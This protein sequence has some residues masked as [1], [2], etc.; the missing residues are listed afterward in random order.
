[1]HDRNG[2]SRLP[3]L[4]RPY[5]SRPYLSRPYLLIAAALTVILISLVAAGSASA[6][7][8]RLQLDRV[9]LDLPGPPSR[10][11]SVDLD[12]DGLRD[13][14]VLVAFTEWDQLSIEESTEMDGIEGLVEVLTIVPALADRREL[15]VFL[16]RPGGGF[17]AVDHVLPVGREI[18]ALE[19][20]TDAVPVVTLT[21]DGLSALRL[22]GAERLSFEPLVEET[23]V[24]AGVGTFLPRLPM[25]HD[26]DGDGNR[27]VF[28]PA[29]DGGAVYLSSAETIVA[30]AAS[31]LRL[32]TDRRRAGGRT[33]RFFPMPR[34]EDVDGDGLP[35][36][37]F[38][39][40][41]AEDGLT[42]QVLGN[43]GQGRFVAEPVEV[44]L[45]EP[46]P[47][48]DSETEATAEGTAERA[49]ARSSDG[50][51]C[52]E[53]PGDFGYFGDLDGDGR[54]EFVRQQGLENDDAGF[55]ESLDQAK[56]PPFRYY[57]YRSLPNLRAEAEPYAV[58]DALGYT[59]ESTSDDG[60]SLFV[61]GGFQDL[62]GDGLQDLIA[63]TLDFSLFQAVRILATKTLSI[64]MDFHVYCQQA[65]GDFKA[66]PNLDL[67]GKFKI[68]LN[69]LQ[70]GRLSLFD[71]DFDGDGRA[72][73]VQLGR[74]KNVTIHRGREGCSYP[75]EPD[76][77]L[78]LKE[79]PRNLAL[80][81][82]D[83]FDADGLSDLLVV[84]PNKVEEAGVTPPVRLD[85]YLS[86]GAR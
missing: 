48:D 76:L 75:A 42:F 47:S 41:Q 72:D 12:T 31:R 77:V 71:G 70:L 24:L 45:P 17:R 16:G 14:V 54:A 59:F 67:S 61:P 3:R 46:C 62:D 37:I 2:Q 82:V 28:F 25:T 33:T 43:R 26:L 15:H 23:P 21:D 1:M 44:T 10:F 49:A 68:D 83:D 86:G 34:V 35:E 81:H 7:R 63:L 38:R 80:V 69:N 58:F 29:R 5:L 79:E 19:P 64:G 84:Q 20:G 30:E 78:K 40:T 53:S 36:L 73:F 51:P 56:R 13:L 57:L 39:D 50:D 18:L 52:S 4:S 85:L 74:G 65:D 66:V 32:P 55:R 27:D 60:D 8:E 6:R 22:D 9:S 11:L